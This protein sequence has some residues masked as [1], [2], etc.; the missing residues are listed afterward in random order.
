MQEL[1]D[2][3]LQGQDPGASG[4]LFSLALVDLDSILSTA[5]LLPTPTH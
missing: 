3:S 5:R 1:S 4:G 2:L